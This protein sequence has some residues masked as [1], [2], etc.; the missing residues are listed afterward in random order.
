VLDLL[1]PFA[2]PLRLVHALVGV[3]LVSGLVGRWVALAHAERAARAADLP[4][5]RVLH[6]GRR[7]IES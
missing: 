4:A 3:L 5:V 6:N 1:V 2:M 7:P